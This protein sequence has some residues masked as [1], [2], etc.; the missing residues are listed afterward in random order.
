MAKGEKSLFSV[1]TMMRFCGASA[2]SFVPLHVALSRFGGMKSVSDR[3][4]HIFC[5]AR[6]E[7]HKVQ[8]GASD[9]PSLKQS[10]WWEMQS[11]G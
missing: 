7:K 8:E 10:R 11:L 3:A 9:V 6:I 2:I 5:R 4:R 1:C